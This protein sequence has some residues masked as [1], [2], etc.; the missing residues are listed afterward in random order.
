[1]SKWDRNLEKWAQL[2][3]LTFD[4]QEQLVFYKRILSVDKT[5]PKRSSQRSHCVL[6]DNITTTDTCYC[7][8][9]YRLKITLK[10]LKYKFIFS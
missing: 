6:T 1:M 8:T 9:T 3:N 10:K 2:M 5:I 7:L 4:E